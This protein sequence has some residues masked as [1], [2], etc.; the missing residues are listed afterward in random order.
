MVLSKALDLTLVRPVS[1]KFSDDRERLERLFRSA[2]VIDGLGNCSA[3]AISEVIYN[4]TQTRLYLGRLDHSPE[5]VLIKVAI[6]PDTGLADVDFARRQFDVLAG[7]AAARV[8]GLP[9]RVPRPFHLFKDDAVIVQSWID[10]RGLDHVIVDRSVGYH[11]VEELVRSAGEWLG[12][13]HLAAGGIHS[14]VVS[15]AQLADEISEGAKR[16]ASPDPLLDRAA[17]CLSEYCSRLDNRTQLL[18]RLHCDFKPANLILS[19]EGLFGIDFHESNLACVCFDIAHFWNAT[20]LDLLKAGRFGFVAR[21]ARL[22]RSFLAGY[23][24]AAPIPEDAA[25]RFFLVYDL[26]RYVLQ[27]RGKQSVNIREGVKSWIV[28]R[29]LDRR[30][31]SLRKAFPSHGESKS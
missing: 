22:E 11:R 16:H 1:T 19:D 29:L 2:G 10:G 7:A 15:L 14:R 4:S 27:H 12:R 24:S 3:I 6:D 13:F 23:Q 26:A 25:L 17:R 21:A 31:A 5:K 20:M 9:L 8:Q 30:L 18:T 28:A